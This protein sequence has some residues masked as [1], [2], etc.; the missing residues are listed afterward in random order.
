V[1]ETVDSVVRGIVADL[2]ELDPADL[3]LE[4]SFRDVGID[5]LLAMEIAVHV[6][7]AMGVRFADDD[8]EDVTTVGGLI[9]LTARRGG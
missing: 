9:D 3:T 5:S 2:A 7:N 1:S 4:T 8:L 6:E